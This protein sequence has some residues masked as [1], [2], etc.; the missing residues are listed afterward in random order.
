MHITHSRAEHTRELLM[1]QL[2]DF[3][4]NGMSKAI[5]LVPEQ[6]TLQ[7]ELDIVDTL[8][9]NGSFA[10]QV[11][12]PAKLYSRIFEAAGEPEGIPIDERGRLLILGAAIR[13]IAADLN[14]YAGAA[15]KPGFVAKAL[16][17]ISELKNAGLTPDD[18][19]DIASD[20]H[21]VALSAKLGDIAY[22]YS[23]YDAAL[24]G[25]FIDSADRQRECLRR[26]EYADC[27]DGADIIMYGFDMIT[28]PL[29]RLAVA[30][31]KRAH[32][33][34]LIIAM[35][36]KKDRDYNVYEAV[37]LSLNRLAAALHNAEEPC[38]ISYKQDSEQRTEIDFMRHE[39]FAQPMQHI[40]GEPRTIRL[41]ALRDPFDEAM[42]IACQARELARNGMRWRDMAVISPYMDEY[43]HCLERAFELYQIPLFISHPRA[44]AGEPL[45]RYV[46]AALR[47][48]SHGFR[49]EDVL[50]CLKSGFGLT[51]RDAQLLENYIIQYGITGRK[52]LN[53]FKRGG[54]ERVAI[55]ETLRDKFFSP[56]YSLKLRLDAAQTMGDQAS[57]L[58]MLLEE[59]SALD[60][61]KTRQQEI[62]SSSTDS[63]AM[64]RIVEAAYASQVW[65]KLIGL[66]D[67]L[68]MLLG[69]RQADTALLSDL[70]CSALECD[71]VHVLPQSGDAVAAG[72][73]GDIKVGRVKVLFMSGMQDTPPESDAQ[74]LTDAE[75]AGIEQSMH[76]FL[77]FNSK[78]KQ[79]MENVDLMAALS[80]VERAIICSYSLSDFS[81]AGQRPNN[82]VIKLKNAF[83]DMKQRGLSDREHTLPLRMG[84]ASAAREQIA[85]ISR[86]GLI[87]GSI[88][89]VVQGTWAALYKLPGGNADIIERALMHEVK[90]NDLP[91]P[92]AQKLH[93]GLKTVSISRLEQ[94]ARCPFAE[95][96]SYMLKPVENK[97]YE[98]NPR[99]KG[100]FYHDALEEFT[101]RIV[102][103]GGFEEFTAQQ[104]VDLMDNITLEMERKL[105][106]EMPLN[107]DSL[108]R[109]RSR[110]MVRTVKR[111]ASAMARQMKGSAYGPSMF[112]ISFGEAGELSLIMADGPLHVNGR[113]DRVDLL[114]SGDLR[115]L[116][117]IDYKLGGKSASLSEMYYGLQLQ[118]LTY[119]CAA[120]NIKP[121][122]EPAAALY[123]AVKDPVIDASA[124]NSE[125]IERERVKLLRMSGLVVNDPR[126]IELTAARPEEAIPIRFTKDGTPAHT[127]WLVTHD[128]LSLLMEHAKVLICSIASEIRRGVTDITPTISNGHTSCDYCDYKGICQF[129]PALPG[130]RV[131]KLEKLSAQDVIEKIRESMRKGTR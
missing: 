30:L 96:V 4:N 110:D 117:V 61:L 58:F 50:D 75:R 112:E 109:A 120:L 70:V 66:I 94:H 19:A 39:L 54:A 41:Q 85:P 7:T 13:D 131:R 121:G 47:A 40:Q 1:T 6:I 42:E 35:P 71:E 126:M 55:V 74:L 93:H 68:Y 105:S 48:I 14:W 34:E 64:R 26:L 33:L 60:L 101:R 9:L 103:G 104:L 89:H 65:N 95:F 43:R 28:P 49:Q 107:D 53:P 114:E 116:R 98:L 15:E 23:A 44:L 29:E 69:E 10:I 31:C 22:I 108:M 18:V 129:M 88:P 2:H 11:M 38:E 124:L 79:L 76:V 37:A 52:F 102:A 128:E 84:S 45:P 78:Q 17:Q 97:K 21:D 77:G 80:N 59:Q 119:L 32:S 8:E 73:L 86:H 113:I 72:R 5:V 24:Q 122:F 99:D 3:I 12:S 83:P 92:L 57:A 56:L 25:R 100:T 62:L 125:Q 67:Q 111:A 63:H 130:A 106:D 27:L 127:D 115:C 51:G 123:F 36:Q 91:R 81:G 118:L 82:V 90:S 46:L 87:D 20:T 16:S